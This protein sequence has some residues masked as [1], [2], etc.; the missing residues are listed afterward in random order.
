MNFVK[1]NQHGLKVEENCRLTCH[2]QIATNI[3]NARVGRSY[4]AFFI[5][6][7]PRNMHKRYQDVIAIG[8]IYG[9]LNIFFIDNF[10]S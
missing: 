6:R 5:S 10:Q 9:A 1:T 8:Y 4:L 7:F 3:E 2:L